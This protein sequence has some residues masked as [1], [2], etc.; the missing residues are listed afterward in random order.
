[1]FNWV[2]PAGAAAELLDGSVRLRYCTTQFSKRFLSW[3]LPSSGR[4]EFPG[5]LPKPDRDATACTDEE[6]LS[7]KSS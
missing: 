2:Y 4:L 3:A 1:M 7:R 6:G 5:Y